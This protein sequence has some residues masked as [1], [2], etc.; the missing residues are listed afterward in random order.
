VPTE[1]EKARGRKFVAR[2]LAALDGVPA[3]D[4][5]GQAWS[6]FARVLL[7]GNEFLYVD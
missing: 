3:A 1:R 6:A 2:Y 5:P 7:A 4:R